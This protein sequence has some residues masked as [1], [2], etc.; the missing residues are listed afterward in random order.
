MTHGWFGKTKWLA[1]A[2]ILAGG[3][4]HP[5]ARSTDMTD[6]TI[7]ENKRKVEQLF[8][9]FNHGDL[10]A[11]ETLVAPEYVG[12]QGGRGP[13][14]FRGVVVGLRGAFPDLRY[15]LDDVVAEGDRVAVQWHWTGTHKAAFRAFPAT[16][17]TVT[18]PGLAIFRFAQGKVVAGALET[19]RLG[20][21]EQI[22]ALP[23]N[24]GQGPPPAAR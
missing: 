21:L 10:A 9:A 1:L 4:A 2:G 14:G 7:S 20:F 13:D 22:G 19:D 8:E 23:P 18:N 17:K 11:L 12:P 5:S 24:V 16:G 15:T 6:A 3:C